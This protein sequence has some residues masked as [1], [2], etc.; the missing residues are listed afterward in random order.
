MYLS[1]PLELDIE[2]KGN[3][4][5]ARLAPAMRIGSRL[6]RRIAACAATMTRRAR[7]AALLFGLFATAFTA[8]I[9]LRLAIWLAALGAKSTF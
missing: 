1:E 8:M 6:A 7:P 3:P 5:V 4:F 9:V 2:N